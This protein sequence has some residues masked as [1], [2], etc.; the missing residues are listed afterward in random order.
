M[1]T[2]PG[3]ASRRR[4][5]LSAST[6]WWWAPGSEVCTWLPCWQ[7]LAERCWSWSSI[8]SLAAARTSLQTKGGPSTQACTTWGA[9]RSMESCWTSCLTSRSS[10]HSSEVSPMASST[11]ASS[12]ERSPPSLLG[13]GGTASL[14]TSRSAFRRRTRPSKS[15]WSWSPSATRGRSS[16]SSASSLRAPWSC[17]WISSSVA[18]S[19][20]SPPERR[21][22]CWT[23]SSP[24]N[25]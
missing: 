2:A 3:T 17:S 22:M 14:R 18:S 10:L 8:M 24:Q 15:T 19:R 4:S 11:I 9:W 1:T 6:W 13:L 20:S 7:S 23:S 16:T 5:S 25:C 12:S 21:R